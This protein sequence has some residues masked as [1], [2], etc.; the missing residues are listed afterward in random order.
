M[1]DARETNLIAGY[2]LQKSEAENNPEQQIHLPI[3][4]C[5]TKPGCG[6][7]NA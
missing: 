1:S 4:S 3:G 6:L 7:R 5:T 2:T